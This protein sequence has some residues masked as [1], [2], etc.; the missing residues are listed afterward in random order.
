MTRRVTTHQEQRLLQLFR[1]LDRPDQAWLLAAVARYRRR[2]RHWSQHV[3]TRAASQR[4][5]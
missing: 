2:A 1:A 5:A 4:R 3:S